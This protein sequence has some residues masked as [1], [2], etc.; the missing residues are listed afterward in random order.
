MLSALSIHTYHDPTGFDALAEEWNRILHRSFA[1]T[2]FLTHEFQRTWWRCLGTGEPL[3]I[4]FRDERG[5]L[6]GI[7]P[8]YATLT[9]QGEQALATVGCTEVADYLD[10]IVV[11]GWEDRV[12]SAL[13]E[14]LAGEHGPAW[15]LL[16]L[17]NIPQDSPTLSILPALAQTRGWHSSITR[18]DVCPIVRLP[19]TWE[20]YLEQLDKK[21][22]H[23]LR[24][25]LRRAEAVAGLH[26]YIVGAEH[27]LEKEVEDFL[28]LMAASTPDKAAFLT[29]QMRHFFRQLARTVYDAGWLQLMFLAVGE[30]KAAAYMNFVY[31]NRVMVYNSGLDWQSFP[32]LGA[33]IV[34]TAYAIRHA[35]EQGYTLFDFM[36]G[37]ERYK[38]QFGGQDVEVRRLIIRKAG[39]R[40]TLPK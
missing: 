13:V 28:A 15:D 29:P 12:Y 27:N 14:F 37:D 35:I 9:P 19:S 39:G 3:I 40:V 18:D 36:Q 8:L 21:D 26:W 4:T 10:F 32:Q 6:V 5:D 24:R 2:I 33:G 7:I 1:D 11:R 38:Y 23:E 17:C 30:R 25:K 16:D 34:L 20:E 31:N 22:R